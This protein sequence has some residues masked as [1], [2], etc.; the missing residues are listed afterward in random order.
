M[1]ACAFPLWTL[2]RTTITTEIVASIE[3]L[4]VPSPSRCQDI[5]GWTPTSASTSGFSTIWIPRDSQFL[6]LRSGIV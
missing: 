4:S 1:P 3:S 5:G 6:G 2:R